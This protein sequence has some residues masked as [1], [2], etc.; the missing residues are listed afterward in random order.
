MKPPTSQFS[1]E[2]MA[3]AAGPKPKIQRN[4]FFGLYIIGTVELTQEQSKGA[5]KAP[6]PGL[7]DCL[8]SPENRMSFIP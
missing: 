5:T 4:S 8:E 2:V 7:K 3:S 6:G 1:F